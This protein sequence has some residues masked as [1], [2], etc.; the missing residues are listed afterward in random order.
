MQFQKKWLC[1]NPFPNKKDKFNENPFGIGI[2]VQP[3]KKKKKRKY[4][5]K[6]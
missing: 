5:Y 1:Q 3:S 6:E 2:L 4:D